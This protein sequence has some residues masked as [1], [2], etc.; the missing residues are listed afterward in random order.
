MSSQHVTVSCVHCGDTGVNVSDMGAIPGVPATY[1]YMAEEYHVRTP[2]HR[3]VAKNSV[4]P[5]T[6]SGKITN[7]DHGKDHNA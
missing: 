6:V 3:A 4:M 2:N 1:S 7:F 5:A